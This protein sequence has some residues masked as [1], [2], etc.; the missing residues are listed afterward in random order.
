MR[1]A[2]VTR[3][4][5]IGQLAEFMASLHGHDLR[6]TYEQYTAS[7]ASREYEC[8]TSDERLIALNMKTWTHREVI[9]VV[10]S[11]CVA[12]K[13]SYVWPPAACTAE[14]TYN[15]FSV[16]DD[17]LVRADTSWKVRYGKSTLMSKVLKHH[18]RRNEQK[19]FDA[20]I[21]GDRK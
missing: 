18:L 10:S 6:K 7:A 19:A 5:L 16:G 20:F 14:H 1:F 12:V 2:S 11:R 4:L 21:S 13:N 9:A 17:D 15:L 8:S 3:A